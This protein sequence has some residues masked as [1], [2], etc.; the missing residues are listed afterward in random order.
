MS[1]ARKIQD[2][3]KFKYFWKFPDVD[4]AAILIDQDLNYV[5]GRV[6]NGYALIESI[7]HPE[8]GYHYK[9]IVKVS[10]TQYV[11]YLR[12]DKIPEYEITALYKRSPY[13][14]FTFEVKLWE[15]RDYF[16]LQDNFN[17]F[18]HKFSIPE[19]KKDK[20]GIWTFVYCS[21]KDIT[22]ARTILKRFTDLNKNCKVK[23][24][25]PA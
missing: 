21:S 12:E 7:P 4:T 15:Y 19:F 6:K 20:V 16:H 22:E 8:T 5:H 18:N 3:L 1:L 10:K 2:S 25:A 17:Y 24:I 23:N 9:D 14:T 13:K 11:R